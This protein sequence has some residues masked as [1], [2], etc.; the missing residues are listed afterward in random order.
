MSIAAAH[1]FSSIFNAA[2]FTIT[3]PNLPPIGL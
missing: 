3:L 1:L 2:S